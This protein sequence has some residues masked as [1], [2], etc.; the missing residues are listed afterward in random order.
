MTH[1][2]LPEDETNRLEQFRDWRKGHFTENVEEKYNSIDGKLRLN[3][4]IL[5]NNRIESHE[6]WK[7]QALGLTFGDP[8]KQKLILEWVLVQDEFG[9]DPALNWP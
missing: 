1:H 7:L 3:Q 9:S 6:T 4:T 8:I 2:F 5:D